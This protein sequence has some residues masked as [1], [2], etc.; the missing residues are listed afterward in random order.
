M[1]RCHGSLF[2]MELDSSKVK[3]TAEYRRKKKKRL[4]ILCLWELCLQ[5]EQ[6]YFAQ[7]KSIAQTF[8]NLFPVVCCLGS[9]TLPGARG[10]WIGNCQDQ[11]LLLNSTTGSHAILLL[12]KKVSSE[13]LILLN[14]CI[15]FLKKIFLCR[16]IACNW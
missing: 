2:M 16:C 6:V 13:L 3:H 9:S 12:R 5:W 14:Y 4:C 7:Y 1:E 15:Y 8:E 11:V 10:K